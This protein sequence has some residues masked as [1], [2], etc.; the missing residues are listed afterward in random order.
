MIALGKR[1]VAA[2]YPMPKPPAWMNA[3]SRYPDLRDPACKGILLDAVRKAFE[4]PLL[5]CMWECGHPYG[6]RWTVRKPTYVKPLSWGETEAHALVKALE[7]AKAL[8]E[9]G[10]VL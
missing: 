10:E 4:E 3:V 8:K 5:Y 9:A 6:E 7:T 2:G 1:A